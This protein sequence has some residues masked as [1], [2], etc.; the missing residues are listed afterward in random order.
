MLLDK[1]L[2]E[3][4]RGYRDGSIDPLVV[5]NEAYSQIEKHSANLNTLIS[6]RDKQEAIAQLANMDRSLPLYGL[7]YVL[8]DSYATTELRTTA[9]SKILDNFHPAYDATIHTKLKAAG[10]ILVGKGNMDAWG[11]GAHV[12]TW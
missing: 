9:A 1:S 3:L 2:K 7:P 5:L 11:H 6:V 4:L 8:K 12:T 10:A